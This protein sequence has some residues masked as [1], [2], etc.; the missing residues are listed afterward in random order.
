MFKI[1]SNLLPYSPIVETNQWGFQMNRIS[2]V[3]TTATFA[4]IAVAILFGGQAASAK[5]LAD[6]HKVS[7]T[8]DFGDG[9]KVSD[10]ADGSGF[11]AVGG[12]GRFVYLAGPK[13]LV[14]TDEQ[15]VTQR[16]MFEQ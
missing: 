13:V 12:G 16:F 4:F 9:V 1:C 15:G 8:A 7:K 10:Y 14:Y 5:D 11:E 3:T 2:K 6:N